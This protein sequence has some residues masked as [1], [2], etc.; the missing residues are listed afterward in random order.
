MHEPRDTASPSSSDPMGERFIRAGLLTPAQVEQIMRLQ[1]M[2]HLRFGEAAV[3]LGLLEQEKVLAVLNEQFNYATA[4]ASST[5]LS[6]SLAIAHAPSS[7]EAEAIRKIRSAML[8]LI[9]GRPAFSIAI[10]SPR[11]G[12][13]RTYLAASLAIAFSQSGQKAVLVN[14]DLRTT[15]ANHLYGLAPAQDSGRPLP[16]LSTIL[17]GRAELQELPAVPGFPSLSVLDAGPLPPNPQELLNEPRLRNLIQT[18]HQTY[19]IVIVD[20]PPARDSQDASIIVRQSDACILVGRKDRSK[21]REMASLRDALLNTRTQLAGVVYNTYG[22]TS[23][24][25]LRSARRP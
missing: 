7:A 8:A 3:K 11:A 13:G 17:A 15:A 18:L 23:R 19:E 2:E 6:S 1:S 21:L 10:A 9:A 5:A 14:A 24:S 16:G 20:T 12:E 4:L 22:T 25:W